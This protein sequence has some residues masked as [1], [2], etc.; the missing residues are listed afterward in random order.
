MSKTYRKIEI[1][2]PQF[3]QVKAYDADH[4]PIIPGLFDAS[5]LENCSTECL[6]EISR[7]VEETRQAKSM[8]REDQREALRR[9]ADTA[10]GYKLFSEHDKTSL[11]VDIR[12]KDD[13]KGHNAFEIVGD[14]PKTLPT[15][16]P[17]DRSANVVNPYSD[18]LFTNANGVEYSKAEV[19]A[20]AGGSELERKLFRKMMNTDL[21]RLNSIL[22]GN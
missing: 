5:V 1:F 18:S 11:D 16:G 17:M 15:A 8:S 21:A 10:R 14:G 3:G 20:L 6:A 22:A 7:R 2:M 9:A 19:Y 4:L 12:R 13:G